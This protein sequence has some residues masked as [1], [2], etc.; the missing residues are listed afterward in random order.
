MSRKG[1]TRLLRIVRNWPRNRADHQA[2]ACSPDLDRSKDQ[3]E[4]RQ[5]QDGDRRL[6]VANHMEEQIIARR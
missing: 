2:L 6:G 3:S 4:P 1:R 5:K